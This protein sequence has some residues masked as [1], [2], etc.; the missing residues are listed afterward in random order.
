MLEFVVGKDGELALLQESEILSASATERWR[1]QRGKSSP[2]FFVPLK[3]KEYE[4]DV[5]IEE[6]DGLQLV[7]K[8]A[9]NMEEM[10]HKK[11]EA[12]RVSSDSGNRG[13]RVGIF[14]EEKQ[15]KQ[16]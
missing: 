4:K 12:V 10:F 8:L 3:Y 13:K 2:A 5:A 11:S 7:K 9:K 6:I 16:P 14:T 1:Q 15:R